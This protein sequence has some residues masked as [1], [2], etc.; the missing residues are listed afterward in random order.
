LGYGYKMVGIKEDSKKYYT[1]K[2]TKKLLKISDC[3]LAHLRVE[4][5][6]EFIKEGNRFM[7][8]IEKMKIIK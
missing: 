3:K 7:Y 8:L 2:E 5:K 6:L 1:S 4:G